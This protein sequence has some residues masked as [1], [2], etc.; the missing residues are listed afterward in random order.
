MNSKALTFFKQMAESK[1]LNANSV[2][3]AHNSDYTQIDAD[4]ILECCADL[5][6]PLSLVRILDIGSG[7]GLVINKLYRFVKEIVAVDKF[8]E[9][10]KYICSPPIKVINDDIFNFSSDEKFELITLFAF[11]HYFDV[12]EAKE[13]YHRFAQNINPGGMM[14][15]KNQFGV[16]EDVIIDKYSEE[17]K[18]SYYSEYRTTAHEIELLKACGIFTEYKVVDIYPPECNRWDNTHFYA[19]VAIRGK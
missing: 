2:K 12:N 1:D 14:I 10:T 11:M 9:F 18:R 13:I 3:L 5:P 15:I 4:F 7:S 19:I 8:P 16:Y 6:V 17:Q